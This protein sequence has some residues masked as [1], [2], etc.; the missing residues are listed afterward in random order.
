MAGL[1]FR[2]ATVLH[3]LAPVSASVDAEVALLGAAFNMAIAVLDY[4]VDEL[5][6]GNLVFNVLNQGLV[7]RIFEPE[8]QSRKPSLARLRAS[9]EPSIAP[10]V[11]SGRNLRLRG[12]EIGSSQWQ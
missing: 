7:N 1:G 10:A 3:G 9:V 2:Q 4:I 6:Q 8:G 11:K 12:I 5:P